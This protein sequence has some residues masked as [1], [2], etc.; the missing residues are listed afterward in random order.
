MGLEI[1]ATS[2]RIKEKSILA[3]LASK[4]LRSRQ[5]AIVIGRTIHLHGTPKLDFIKDT[6]WYKHELKHIEQFKQ[7]GVVKFLFL[8]ILYT[9]RYGYYQNPFEVEARN[10]EIQ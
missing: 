6:R 2:I 5:C 3:Y 8:Y 4:V 9:F 10:A 1:E 7:Y